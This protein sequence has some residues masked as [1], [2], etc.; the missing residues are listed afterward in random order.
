SYLGSTDRIADFIARADCIV[1]PSYYREGV[2]RSLLEAAAMGKP[3]ITTDRPG[4]R[5]AVTDGVTGFLCAP[6]DPHDLADKMEKMI[7]LK[8]EE[9]IRMGKRGREK[10][11]NEFDE[12]IVLGAYMNVIKAVVRDPRKGNAP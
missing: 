10:M 2:P 5:D 12:K 4:C 9:R 1:L 7:Q 11:E 3:I 6:R 8:P